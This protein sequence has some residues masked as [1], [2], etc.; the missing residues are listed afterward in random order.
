MAGTDTTAKD[1]PSKVTDFDMVM[2]L[3]RNVELEAFFFFLMLCKGLG[4]NQLLS[5]QEQ[6]RACGEEPNL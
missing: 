6:F 3:V 1:N 4:T 5:R 2:Q